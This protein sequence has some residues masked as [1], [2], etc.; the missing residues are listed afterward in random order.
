MK[1]SHFT[2]VI[3]LSISSLVTV[4]CSGTSGLMSDKNGSTTSVYPEWYS[5][6]AAFV[7]DTT[8]SFSGYATVL[9]G[10]SSAAI[11]KAYN[12]AAEELKSGV[13]RRL[14]SV[15]KKA[16]DEL[17]N[18]SGLNTS[19]FIVTLRNAETHIADAT[20]KAHAGTRVNTSYSGYRG[21]ARATVNREALMRQLDNAMRRYR[22]AWGAMKTSQAFSEF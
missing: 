6:G 7:A 15:R 21:F 4:S 19:G 13:S 3:A 22:T 9:A 5:A 11:E 12:H 2:A 1:F 8:G 18:S 14:E 20:E 17:G 16:A 10:D